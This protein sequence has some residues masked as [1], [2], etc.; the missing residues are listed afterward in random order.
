M[1]NKKNK[2]TGLEIDV[3]SQLRK[4][5]RRSKIKVEYE[6]IY[7]PYVVTA[8]YRP[9]FVVDFPNG[10]RLIIEAKGWF[11]RED[12]VKMRKVK[13]ANP[14]LDIRMLFQKNNKA[15][16]TMTYVDWCAKYGFPCAVGKV[17]KEWLA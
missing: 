13:E 8:Y 15:T 17:P 11:R 4:L 12:M 10:R 16:K 2:M 7:L 6:P 5:T 9:D 14:D 3:Q 1:K